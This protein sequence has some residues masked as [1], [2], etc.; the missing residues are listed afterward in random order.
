[1]P[2]YSIQAPNGK[3][4]TIDGPEGASREDVVRAV[5]AKLPGE[6]FY[7]A[8]K[9]KSG[10]KAQIE[11]GASSLLESAATGVQGIFDAEA[12]AKRQKQVQERLG[13]EYD[14]GASFEK[15]KER[16]SAPDGGVLAAGKEILRQVP[17]AI[18]EQAPNLAASLGGARLGAMAGSTF[19]P[20]GTAVG[21]IGGGLAVPFLS[22]A[23]QNLGRQEEEGK[24]ISA[25]AAYGTALPQA[26]A[27]VVADRVA[28][29]GKLFNKLIGREVGA[30][31][32]E[33]AE[34]LAQ[35]SLKKALLTG[36]ART[37]ATEVPTEV[38]QSALERAQ[39]GLPLTTPD[40]LKEYGEAAYGAALF[41]PV[42]AVGGYSDRAAAQQQLK[43]AAEEKAQK[44]AQANMLLQQQEEAQR[45]Q[46]SGQVAQG[47][48]AFAQYYATTPAGQAEAI[49]QQIAAAQ[50]VIKRKPGKKATP[51]EKQQ[52]IVARQQAQ[53][54]LVSL[55]QQREQLVS[56]ANAVG[57]R[58]RDE[59]LAAWQ[60][61]EADR[62]AYERQVGAPTED[63]LGERMAGQVTDEFGQVVDPTAYTK[64]AVARLENALENTMLTAKQRKELET[65]LD[66]YKQRL[67]A[68]SSTYDVG[69]ATDKRYLQPVRAGILQGQLEEE[70]Q[71]LSQQTV[72]SPEENVYAD[73]TLGFLDERT[74]QSKVLNR[75]L[76]TIGTTGRVPMASFRTVAVQANRRMQ[77][78]DSIFDLL[79]RS[80]ALGDQKDRTLPGTQEAE[81]LQNQL[82]L[83]DRNLNRWFNAMGTAA[84]AEANAQRQSEGLAPLTEGQELSL[85][86]QLQQLINARGSELIS[87]PAPKRVTPPK[88]QPE[89]AQLAQWLRNNQPLLEGAES[90]LRRALRDRDRSRVRADQF[91]NDP[92]AQ[93]DM[94]EAEADFEVALQERD[95][96]FQMVND[97]QNDYE[98]LKTDYE[99]R[100]ND[101]NESSKQR[102]ASPQGA[103]EREVESLVA[104]FKVPSKEELAAEQAAEADTFELGKQYT[105]EIERQ[106]D[107]FANV[108]DPESLPPALQQ[109]KDLFD[110]GMLPDDL[111][112]LADR[113]MRNPDAEG[114][115][116]E[117]EAGLR[118]LVQPELPEFIARPRGRAVSETPRAST[119]LATA[120]PVEGTRNEFRVTTPDGGVVRTRVGRKYVYYTTG[121]K[122]ARIA[123]P[124]GAV[125]AKAAAV[126]AFSRRQTEGSTI[127]QT[128]KPGETVRVKQSE[129]S[130][131]FDNSDLLPEGVTDK[132]ERGLKAQLAIVQQELRNAEAGLLTEQQK[133]LNSIYDRVNSLF[134]DIYEAPGK[135]AKLRAEQ[136][137]AQRKALALV[138]QYATQVKATIAA[139]NTMKA[140]YEAKGMPIPD[141]YKKETKALTLSLNRMQTYPKAIFGG[142]PS[143]AS[144]KAEFDAL[145][146][147]YDRLET[148]A[149]ALEEKIP[150]AK[151]A[152]RREMAGKSPAL[153]INFNKLSASARE[154]LLEQKRQGTIELVQGAYIAS[155]QDRKAAVESLRQQVADIE[156]R[157]E[158]NRQALSRKPVK[159]PEER[160]TVAPVTEE[161]QRLERLQA[162]PTRRVERATER[163]YQSVVDSIEGDMQD[164]SDKIN[165]LGKFK[166]PELLALR[167]ALA[168]VK[169]KLRNAKN[170]LKTK[171]RQW[172]SKK[173]SDVEF[174]AFL[175]EYDADVATLEAQKASIASQVKALE[176][177]PEVARRLKRIA[178]VQTERTRALNVLSAERT[179]TMG[180]IPETTAP[181]APVDPAE[182]ALQDA[183]DVA[184]RAYTA[185]RR[186]R[187]IA[188]TA[189]EADKQNEEKRAAF[190]K[191]QEALRNAHSA[192]AYRKLVLEGTAP[193]VVTEEPISRSLLAEYAK[194]K[195]ANSALAQARRIRDEAKA[196]YD[197][198]KKDKVKRAA[199][200]K[201]QD[202]LVS[203]EIKRQNQYN[204]LE[205]NS[206]KFVAATR[207]SGS[208]TEKSLLANYEGKL[209]AQVKLQNQLDL[210]QDAEYVDRTI[211]R[212]E[213]ATTNVAKE[214][215][216][217]NEV[218]ASETSTKADKTAALGRLDVARTNLRN[219]QKIKRWAT[220]LQSTRNALA[221]LEQAQADTK[222]ALD[223]FLSGAI[224]AN[225]ATARQKELAA[226]EGIVSR[227]DIAKTQKP[228]PLKTGSKKPVKSRKRNAA[229]EA[230]AFGDED[231]QY[232]TYGADEYGA[233]RLEERL[234]SKY[235][236]RNPGAGISQ[237]RAQRVV[238]AFKEDFSNAPN[239]TIANKPADVGLTDPADQDAK[240]AYMNGRVYLFADN[241]ANEKDAALTLAHE[242]VGHFGLRALVGN[243]LNSVL[244]RAYS[245][246]AIKRV[247]DERM[248]QGLEKYEAIEE[249]LAEASER[250]EPVARGMITRVVE[251]LRNILRKFG[252]FKNMTDNEVRQLLQD[253]RSAVRDG[254]KPTPPGGG[255]RFRKPTTT[256][257][258]LIAQPQGF[259]DKVGS[260]N[261]LGAVTAFVDR[262]A[263]LEKL[264]QALDPVKATQ[265]MYFYRMYGQR[266]N[267]VNEV[268]NS[269]TLGIT[270]KTR[271]DGK[272]ERI[273]ERKNDN[274]LKAV[275]EALKPAYAA[276]GKETDNEFTL[277]AAATRAQKVGYA[278]LNI[279]PAMQAEVKQRFA[280]LQAMPEVKK[281]FDDALTKYR[282]Y[283]QGL[284]SF[285]Q[286]TGAISKQEYQ[287][288][289]AAGDYV[290]YY[291]KKPDGDIILEIDG[292]PYLRVGNVNENPDLEALKG[293]D[294][295]VLP[296][297]ESALQNTMLLTDM[298][299]KNLANKNLAFTMQEAGM[300]K[301]INLSGKR[302][303]TPVPN[304]VYFKL[305]GEPKALVFDTDAVPDAALAVKALEGV[306][307][308]MPAALR[309]MSAPARL[310]RK[311]VMRNP[312]YVARQLFR[313]SMSSF[314][315]SGADSKPVLGAMKSVLAGTESETSKA[316]R[317]R[318][319]TGGQMLAG[320]PE[321][322]KDI[323]NNMISGKTTLATG[324]AW[325]D[326]LAMRTDVANREA[327]YDSFI[328]QGLSEMEATLAT[329]EQMNFSKQGYSPSMFMLAQ[330]VP[331][332]QSQITGLN[333]LYKAL[334]GKAPFQEQLKVRQKLIKRGMAIAGMTLAYAMMMQD[335]EAYK[336]ATPEERMNNWFVYTPFTTEPIK[337]PIP[338]EIG[339]LTKAIPE[340]I[341]NYMAG[342]VSGEDTVQG[343]T[344]VLAQSIPGGTSPIP[345]AIK[346]PMELALN[347][348]MY[349]L[350]DIVPASIAGRAA[351]E[352]YTDKT[353]EFS[354]VLGSV[355]GVSPMKLDYAFR[356][357][358]ASTGMALL[359]VLNPV[360]ADNAV[361]SPAGRESSL[362]LVGT[363]FQPLNGQG[364]IRNAYEIMERVDR[365]AQSYND[366]VSVDPS[367]ATE[368]LTK[369]NN[370]LRLK[371]EAGA[372][373]KKLG[374]WA[375][376]ERMVRAAPNIDADRKQEMLDQLF[377]AKNAYSRRLV[378]L[379]TSAEL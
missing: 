344:K 186:Q 157:I 173:L 299:L 68:Y 12:A 284:L 28:L 132:G 204:I 97:A 379:A 196:A 270:T 27:E 164:V 45:Q 153:P 161:Q 376:M 134:R 41:S 136:T 362:P 211:Q 252:L 175:N 160:R 248:A 162:L 54:D 85:K 121:T 149:N 169:G 144:P 86:K 176:D 106:T 31:G 340:A 264:G 131:D 230:A 261:A 369:Y 15:V 90:T 322:A 285:L 96:Y 357:L 25:G 373:R 82:D 133:V 251:A 269:G 14:Q 200:D 109:A 23:G 241:L 259:K 165:R 227:G 101:F 262:Y 378:E 189:F 64:K 67:A 80:K 99:R 70:N 92:V 158:A 74:E 347:K 231:L 30:L 36:G 295:A 60:Q 282:T 314:L 142:A 297:S 49:D 72:T 114:S 265:M 237:D 289:I 213:T 336:N 125:S 84:V 35:S 181:A 190:D 122:E 331:F 219:A 345:L 222:K 267:F 339:V 179:T 185:A 2:T 300:G 124:E 278:K 7:N 88:E 55:Q 310:L 209:L 225:A 232:D 171:E 139:L 116:R 356:S 111:V 212:V 323:I 372:A 135:V 224:S 4:Y 313:D 20:I 239:I 233:R 354:K 16:F 312:T 249:A 217:Y 199:Y 363:L 65:E 24:P 112:T 184:D 32:T 159:V 355:M 218:L 103:I 291:R 215:A 191:A 205:D 202:E 329:L 11:K 301:I 247:A 104:R 375:K 318:G 351:E 294:S 192:R 277:Y 361:P 188:K 105:G 119:A 8:P 5:M 276:L 374:E 236:G 58:T 309:V 377:Q 78:L 150:T 298:A 238:D 290:P 368:M 288:L 167:D 226:A 292:N 76:P 367:R 283:N 216:A 280:E 3:T 152:F 147:Q 325:L 145:K 113:V 303:T 364:N 46:A 34:A 22:M 166:L 118:D 296:F 33:A 258:R 203:A 245:N 13:R 128:T 198:D 366:I 197:A 268:A 287:R 201:A 229:A 337:V 26:A 53:R 350:Q 256:A 332:L 10:I 343:L 342:T 274:S 52:I 77:S 56:D 335:D 304:S 18:A 79:E 326:R 275:V 360:I 143:S 21:A 293:G 91:P 177:R 206:D 123:R 40:A 168:G 110:D 242:A 115:M 98:M 353:T 170:R 193:D 260:L 316:L 66:Q 163:Y 187:D 38:L 240:G 148:E 195:R 19:G 47:L 89:Q 255:T 279:D 120:E 151:A 272:E 348:S 180:R 127:T 1:M 228:T 69:A 308:A 194:F 324:I 263:P 365:A 250:N 334:A 341:Y 371:E 172:S 317:A 9:P 62:L 273:V 370:E 42:G 315:L 221:G 305:D 137:E 266:M 182:Q 17:L 154:K 156:Q 349:T 302:S 346:L 210:L 155:N 93:R 126:A 94:L 223:A 57:P 130:F 320:S 286:E 29:G 75:G 140:W 183:Y 51:E 71:L 108:A 281:A 59:A 129:L 333:V 146:A 117:L 95:K 141:S 254:G 107:P 271:A 319:I 73:E 338:F 234:F 214:Q 207:R 235:S 208:P 50:E 83:V 307:V 174:S 257:Q 6:D 37:L 63:I 39:A 321:E 306:K 48:D 352:Q 102:E 244:D 81:A 44:E 87:S 328:K 330:T 243:A 61:Q 220:S 43:T 358:G 100:V 359:S 311:M 246:S 138:E 327:T 178:A 253:A